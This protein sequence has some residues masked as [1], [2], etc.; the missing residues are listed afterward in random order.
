MISGRGPHRYY[1]RGPRGLAAAGWR[2]T[3]ARRHAL[4]ALGRHPAACHAQ[5][6]RPPATNPL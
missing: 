1:R 5:G 2:P 3:T 6:V 4:R